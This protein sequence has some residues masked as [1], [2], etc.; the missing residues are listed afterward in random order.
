M[1]VPLGLKDIKFEKIA[2]DEEKE[3]EEKEKEKREEEK[4]EMEEAKAV[5]DIEDFKFSSHSS[6]NSN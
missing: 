3:K 5:T 6:F 1:G 4:Q 2:V